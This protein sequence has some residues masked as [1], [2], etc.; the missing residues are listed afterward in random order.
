MSQSSHRSKAPNRS[1]HSI[2]NGS[3]KSQDSSRVRR[4][5]IDANEAYLY[6]L[7]V[8][9]L[10]YL[11]QPRV[12]RKRHVET[13][14]PLHRSTTSHS[15]HD[16][17]NDFTVVRDSKSTRFPHDFIKELEKRLKGILIGTERR[18]EYHDALV[19]RIFA[20]FLNTLS[21]PAF[22]KR[23]EA[24]RRAEDLVLIF[25]S[26][27]TK[28]LQKGKPP[29]D[30]GVKRMV[31]RHVALFVRLLT[32]ILKDRD[33]ARDKP[34]LASRL[35]A[36]ESKLLKGDDNL[37]TSQTNGQ[38]TIVEEVVP[39]SYDVKDMAL[40]QVVG[41]IFGLTNT[42]MQSDIAKN[43]PFWTEKAALQDL[44]TYQQH[45][46][47]G[48]NLT[49]NANDFDTQEAYEAWKKS[50]GPELSQLMLAIM[51]ANPE[52]AKS[53]PGGNLPQFNP[54]AVA[55]SPTDSRYAEFSRVLS[56]PGDPSSYV[57][58]LPADLGS[59]DLN[60]SEPSQRPQ[61]A[62]QVYTFIPSDPRAM[63]RFILRQALSHDLNDKTN[64]GGQPFSKKTTELLSEIALRWRLPKFTRIVLFLDVVREKVV[65]QAIGLETVDAAFSYVKDPPQEDSKNKRSSFIVSSALY[66]R[67]N[68][69]IADFALM[70]KILHAL[71]EALLR[72]L[73]EV[74]MTA[75]AD[76]AELQR[77]G[78]IMAIVDD[79]I[80]NDP[81]F[82]QN[83]ED[84][85]NFKNAVIDGL[86]NEARK[87]YDSL[88]DRQLPQQNEKWEFYHIQEL[89]K[90]VLK[91]AE[92]VQKR[93]RKNPEIL[94]INPLMILLNCTL[95]AFAE[96]SK[97]MVEQ[98]LNVAQRE[99]FEVAIQDGFDLY[100]EL[101][102]FRR[103]HTEALPHVPFPYKIEDLLADFVWRWIKI[104]EEQVIGW[105]ENAV[106]QDR[107]VVRTQHPGQVPTEDERH[108]TSVIDV[109]SS[110]GQ[111]IDQVSQL[112]WDDDLS[113][114]KFMTALSKALGLGIARYCE[115]L[116][117]M[118]GKEM[119]RLTPEQE[120]AATMTRQEKWVQ[121]AKDTWNNKERVE[122]FQFYPESFV[123]LNNISFAIHQW[124]KLESD[125]NVDAC[126]EV[127]KKHTP[128]VAHRP[129]KTSNYVF[130]IKIVE[131]ED[132][133]ACDVNGFSDPYVVLTDEYQKRLF[134][135]RIVYRNLN[136][137]WDES[138]DITTQGPLNLIATVWDWDAVGDHDYVGRTS[139]KLDPSHFSDF[140]PREYW[141]DLDTQGRVMV[142][143]SMEGERDDIQF[144]FG[145]AFRNLQRT[146]RD[147]TRKITD[148]LSAYISHCLSR[149][150]LRSL[151][152]RGISISSVSSYFARNRASVV[153]TT[154]MP[155]D[156]EIVNALKPLFDYFDDNFAIMQQTLTSDAMKAVMTRIWKEVLA[157][158]EGLLVPPLSDKPS[159][160]K[161]LNQ[162]E[163]DVVF[164]WLQSLLE[165][166]NAVDEDTGE[167]NGVPLPVLKN[168]KYH[169]LQMLNFFYFEP[170]ESLIRE[171]ERMASATVASQQMQRSRL[172][173]PATLGTVGGGGLLNPGS[174]AG[175]RRAKSIMLSRNLGTMRKAK[176]EKWKA[177][178]A[179]PN[180]DMILRIL[181]MRPEAAGY[182]R[183]RSRQKERLAA[184][185]AAEMIV[186]QSLLA[187]GGRM[188]GPSVIR[189]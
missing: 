189:R 165:F 7:R 34:E 30:D 57:L 10:S 8:A 67:Y 87:V 75:Y 159:Q 79:H 173:A 46:N 147:M 93:F 152:N 62:S 85:Q 113:Y 154:A 128:P 42:M 187:G 83:R 54:Q 22:K 90:A 122:P 129:R 102:E 140:L 163:L 39:L 4:K 174:L 144:Y 35:N 139:L 153:P 66:D 31:D 188:T 146:Q 25:F 70:G 98:I 111:V 50:E 17:M 180:D 179:D 51:Q 168:P 143:V 68:W 118:F 71:H 186:R 60:A 101:S 131:A 20:I 52:L 106:K 105:V 40:V 145:K 157:T 142:R 135:S 99:G 115:L 33:W 176:E 185:A 183:D 74:I 155:T 18:P 38:M 29:G 49:L 126:A 59:L 121:L 23:M 24:D 56:Q 162:Q 28:E 5:S 108:S 148:K 161:P 3:R 100:K 69:T 80:Q 178:Q 84:L 123:K 151:L 81:N 150:A 43:K 156:A 55:T 160:Q 73:Y 127:I 16:L 134:K 6:A 72:D 136:P 78:A 86:A 110:F 36:L 149:R 109:Y 82:T 77:V 103:V 169:E 170:T 76:K 107:F 177:A 158:I 137:R 44:K 116:D 164:K 138:V 125:V 120:A 65:E 26:N 133:K 63:F 41:Q 112:N 172:S 58:D 61:D 9:Y 64:D 141:L 182:L 119:D 97:A 13:K 166:F 37:A 88:L 14:P 95:P 27:A 94:G 91:L 15:F 114:A 1:V 92:R 45:L 171:S 175:A 130:T 12:T 132:L 47:L 124:D 167:A 21:D 104:T 181:R 19:K 117:Q 11:L 53:T 89:A 48:T 96:D 184:A 32:L 2:H